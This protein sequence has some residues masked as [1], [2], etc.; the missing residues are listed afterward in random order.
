MKL[1][2]QMFGIFSNTI[3]MG[4][5]GKGSLIQNKW[6]P[7]GVVDMQGPHG[8]NITNSCSYLI[9]F[10]LFLLTEVFENSHHP[11]Y[12]MD[13]YNMHGYNIKSNNATAPL[14]LVN[15]HISHNYILLHIIL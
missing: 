13:G 8:R 2:Q 10:W 4:S 11:G 9:G 15:S 6:F 3:D 12:N 7:W 1:Y 5:T 14:P